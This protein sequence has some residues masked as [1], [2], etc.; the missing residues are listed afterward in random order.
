MPELSHL[1]DEDRI[2]VRRLLDQGQ[3]AL[4]AQKP[5]YADFLD[6]RQRELINRELVV[7]PGLR[8]LYYGGYR[9]AERQRL[10]LA[11]DYLLMEAIDPGLAY[12]SIAV[13]AAGALA[14]HDYLGAILGLGLKREKIGDLIVLE[15]ACQ[16]VVA[17]EVASF[18]ETSLR[19]VGRTEVTAALIEP[20][21]L[22]VPLEHEKEIR[23]TVASPR[24][25][26]VASDG[27]GVS[28]TR[29]AREIK[30]GRVRVNWQIASNPDK[31]VQIG[32]VISIRGRGRV[33]VAETTGTTKKGRLGL[34]LKVQR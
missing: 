33:I 6:P 19:R 3:K 8:C 27:F 24:L 10:V 25:D 30:A 16:A 21:Q 17:V 28:R 7:L 2:L 29:M 1:T 4:E 26:A 32:D 12:V 31:L 9:R 34:V 23:T 5:I 11:A 18:V 13:P 20:E 14:H 22:Q 15:R